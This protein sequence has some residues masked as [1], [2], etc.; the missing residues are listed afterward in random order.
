MSPHNFCP[1]PEAAPEPNGDAFLFTSDDPGE[2]LLA[3]R[4]TIN[5]LEKA[6][7]LRA[8]AVVLHLGYVPFREEVEA[9]AAKWRERKEDP[10][11]EAARERLKKLKELRRE[12]APVY[13]DRVFLVP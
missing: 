7:D 1:L 6:A 3:V 11:V 10:E 4:A 2:R 12:K 13:L 9:F 8:R 5:T